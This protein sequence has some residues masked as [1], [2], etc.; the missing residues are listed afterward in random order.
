MRR[1]VLTSLRATRTA[2]GIPA[3]IRRPGTSARPAML[4][5]MPRRSARGFPADNAVVH[6][7]PHAT[8]ATIE[9]LRAAPAARRSPQEACMTS[10]LKTGLMGY[11]FAG[12]TFH[13]PVI[14][15][16][17]RASVAAIATGQ[18]DKARADYPNATIVP[19]LDALLAL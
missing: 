19:D 18:P 3:D 17:G 11:G 13:A 12:A 1:G 9:S 5:R 4:T 16:C 15:H 8:R 7:G 2:A 10:L 14:E 6:T